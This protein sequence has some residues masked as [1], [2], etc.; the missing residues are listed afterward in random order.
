[1][2]GLEGTVCPECGA[3]RNR[4]G[5]IGP[6]PPLVRRWHIALVSWALI[7]AALAWLADP[8]LLGCIPRPLSYQEDYILTP[9]SKLYGPLPFRRIG[10]STGWPKLGPY[11]QSPSSAGTTATQ[12]PS[13][14]F[15]GRFITVLDVHPQSRQGNYAITR[16]ENRRT[17]SVVPSQSGT[18]DAEFIL[19]WLQ[20]LGVD[21]PVM[22]ALLGFDAR[23]SDITAEAAELAQLALAPRFNPLVYKSLKHFDVSV[24]P[25]WAAASVSGEVALATRAMVWGVIGGIGSVIILKRYRRDAHPRM[26]AAA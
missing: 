11:A 17:Y 4:F 20:Q 8:L 21:A 16:I 1:V 10:Y 24:T 19:R 6:M 15:G 25:G 13:E 26:G 9:H 23:Q 18:V 12:I 2:L 5:T 3:D 22:N 14:A 7:V